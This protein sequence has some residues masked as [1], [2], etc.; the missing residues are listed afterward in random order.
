MKKVD[1]KQLLADLEMRVKQ[2]LTTVK[3]KFQSEDQHI[4]AKPAAN[5][6]WSIIQCLAHLNTYGDYYLPRIEKALTHFSGKSVETFTSAWLGTYFIKM[7]DPSKSAKKYKAA[8]LHL[9]PAELDGQAVIATFIHQQ[10]SLLGYL[11]LATMVDLNAIKI[12]I[13]ISKLIRLKL[14][15]VLQFMVVHAERHIQQ[16]NRNL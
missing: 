1:K 6:G 14:G 12:P 5:G 8:N 16:A 3:V 13:S 10:E 11:Q 7:M 4:L 15:D 2:Q 9:P